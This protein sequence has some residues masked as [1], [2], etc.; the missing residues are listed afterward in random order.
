MEHLKSLREFVTALETIGEIQT[1]D[2][3]VDWYLEIGAVIR[4]SYDL[5]VPAPLFTNITGYQ[6]TGFRVVGAPGALSA[7]EHRLARITLALGLPA[8]AT[9]QELMEALVAA[10]EK[11]GM[12]P[13]EVARADAPC[14]QN[15]MLGDDIDLLKFP[16]P[17]IHGNDGGRYIQTWGLNIARTPDGSWT[18]W[19][20]NRMMIHN[21]ER[22]SVRASRWYPPR[23]WI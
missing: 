19:S 13:V 8:D 1:I 10:R 2:H 21:A 4:R 16:T 18:S 15:I 6:D 12:P 9:G 7:P 17:W 14:K 11:P 5:R 3:E 23:Q 20:V 22:I